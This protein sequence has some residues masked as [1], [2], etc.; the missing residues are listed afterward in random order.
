MERG[1]LPARRDADDALEHLY[2]HHRA[3]VF[4]FALRAVRDREEAEDVTQAAFLNAYRALL[5][6]D[7]PRRPRAWLIAIAENVRRSRVR[8]RR[9]ELPLALVE[10]VAPARESSV[11]AGDI[12]EALAGLPESQR[13]ALVLRELAGLSY[14]EIGDVM[15]VSVGSVQMLVFRG[16]RSLRSKLGGGGL[17][18]VP[19]A[20]ESWLQGLVSGGGAA[21]RALAAVAGAVALGATVPSA[22][23]AGPPERPSPA[24]Q[25]TAAASVDV[26]AAAVLPVSPSWA[27]SPVSAAASRAAPAAPL[28]VAAPPEAG[29]RG[30]GASPVAPAPSE[31]SVPALAPAAPPAAVLE[32]SVPSLPLDLSSAAEPG[33][34]P[35]SVDLPPTVDAPSTV[36]V[37]HA[38]APT[39][40]PTVDAPS[41]SLDAPD[42]PILSP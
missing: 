42:L 4:R 26:G 40:T 30:A 25:G 2:R 31:P 15:G 14:A 27:R 5:Q 41:L 32:S 35:P 8:G 6:G 3:E 34:R 22:G 18:W 17:P 38:D 37:P 23:P 1:S 24:P 33:V 12:R 29:G 9:D 19:P 7:V 13:V 39:S 10:Q 11:D 20:L 21:P 36:D 28:R 16:R